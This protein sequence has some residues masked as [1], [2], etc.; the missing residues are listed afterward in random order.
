M[1]TRLRLDPARMELLAVFF[2]TYLP[3][4]PHEEEQLQLE[5]DKSPLK[6]EVRMMEWITSW[7]KKGRQEGIEVGMKKSINDI[8]I[9]MMKENLDPALISKVTGLSL[10]ELHKLKETAQ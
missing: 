10:E 8:A 7:E 5:I 9:K 2:E 3:L 4:K 6:K 1:M